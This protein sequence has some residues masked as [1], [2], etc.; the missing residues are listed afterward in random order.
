MQKGTTHVQ[1][2]YRV[3]VALRN[4]WTTARTDSRYF[5]AG[6][7]CFAMET[8]LTTYVWEISNDV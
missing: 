1:M 3:K 2:A 4:I 7:A 5:A 6:L 8:S